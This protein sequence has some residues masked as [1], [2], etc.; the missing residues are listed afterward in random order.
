[1]FERLNSP[2][3]IFS[4]KLGAALT[5]EKDTLAML[6]RLEE[7][8]QREELKQLLREH[9]AETR[10]QIEVIEQCFALL[11]EE[12]DDS[13]C[14]VTKALAA[15]AET[16]L[17]K[18]DD[19]L[20]DAVILSG[21]LET[22]YHEQAVYETLV[23]HARARGAERVATLLETSLGVERTAG[24]RVKAMAERI[25]VT[26]VATTPRDQ[27]MSSGVKAGL[28][29]GVAAT[30]GAA[31]AAASKVADN[32]GKEEAREAAAE[33]LRAQPATTSSTSTTT[34]SSTATPVGAELND[35]ALEERT[36][37][38][39]ERGGRHAAGS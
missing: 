11:G 4:Y 30:V 7:A 35:A 2:E 18:T 39:D 22:E 15:E 25:A 20:V 27:G 29:A 32:K 28:A 6:G 17:K 24:S 33:S 38:S 5:M 23:L 12:V 36:A 21:A 9:A 26:G 14:P 3:E 10:E 34:T 31:A 16:V 13:P 37:A 19:S 8:A 1:M